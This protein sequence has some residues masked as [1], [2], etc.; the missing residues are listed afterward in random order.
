M[1]LTQESAKGRAFAV[2]AD[3]GRSLQISAVDRR[4]RR[5]NLLVTQARKL[6]LKRVSVQVGMSGS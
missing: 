4:F 3:L 6:E 2:V 5:L 1:S